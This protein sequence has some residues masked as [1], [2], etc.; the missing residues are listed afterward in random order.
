LRAI[1]S[2]SASGSITTSTR[3]SLATVSLNALIALVF[4]SSASGSKTRPLHNTLSTRMT[5]F[6]RNR[7]STSS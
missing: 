6:G 1:V 7:R 5:P 2:P 4:S 3:W